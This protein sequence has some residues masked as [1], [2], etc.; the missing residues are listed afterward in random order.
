MV[1]WGPGSFGIAVSGHLQ[2]E[3][4]RGMVSTV[5][6]PLILWQFLQKQHSKNRV[7]SW[8]LLGGSY[9]PKGC[10][11][12]GSLRNSLR[13]SD[14]LKITFWQETRKGV[15]SSESC[16]FLRKDED[17]A[18]RG[19]LQR[20]HKEVKALYISVCKCCRV[21]DETWYKVVETYS[22]LAEG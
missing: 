21:G 18:A 10:I 22:Y 9:C 1:L 15:V 3:K 14:S 2:N 8:E 12:G 6:L 20:S 13:V 17:S 19:L 11:S 7:G 5:F 16:F 4:D